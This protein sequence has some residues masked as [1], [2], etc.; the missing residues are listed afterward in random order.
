VAALA[1]SALAA[2]TLSTAVQVALW[3]LAGEDAAALLLRDA[4]LAA[5]I[6]LGPSVLPPPAGFDAGVMAAATAVHFALSIVYAA[7]VG[8]LVDG[9]PAGI[10][11]ALGAAFGAALYVVNMHGVTWVYPWF[12]AARGGITA[13]AHVAFGVVAAAAWRAA[14][15]GRVA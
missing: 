4:R 13:I 7:I 11:L 12:A 6:V 1:W 2:A 3:W 5:A 15:T 14:R 9:R 10:A 8:R